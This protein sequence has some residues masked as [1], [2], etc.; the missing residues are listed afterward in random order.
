ML[1]R[2]GALLALFT[3]ALAVSGALARS[4]PIAL[5]AVPPG[6]V[7]AYAAVRASRAPVVAAT[8]AVPRTRLL[9]GDVE[10]ARARVESQGRGLGLVEV[11]ADLHPGVRAAGGAPIALAWLSRGGSAEVAVDAAFEVRGRHRVGAVRVRERGALGLFSTEASAE[12]GADVL[13]M[14][15]WE[16]VDEVP[17]LAR[18]PRFELGPLSIARA[19]GGTGFHG[20]RGYLPGDPMGAVNWRRTARMGRPFVNEREAEVPADM[21]LLVD[22]RIH[23]R[24]GDGYRSTLEAEIRAA[25]TL[26]ERATRD[27]IKTGLVV[28]G[29]TVDWLHPAWGARQRD[30]IVERLLVVEPKGWQPLAPIL[31]ALPGNVLP[32]GATLVLLSPAHVDG[33]LVEAAHALA[34]R[35]VKLV[36]V[37]PAP[38]T[39]ELASLPQGPLGEAAGRILLR[40]RAQY[41][42]DLRLVGATVVDWDVRRPLA[43]ALAEAFA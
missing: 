34:A 43:E 33:T 37:A 41:L 38:E 7:L 39:A 8:L 10:T 26:A 42:K 36:L 23:A 22:A 16:A 11:A 24:V 15:S 19:G 5:A 3:L 28:V 20:V 29:E 40:N 31:I 6:V 13:V 17:A 14:P 25:V 27:R 1:T 9:A 4:W 35:G 30:R 21:V 32:K 12:A 18:R 2:K